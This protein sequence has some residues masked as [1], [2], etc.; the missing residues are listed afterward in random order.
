MDVVP[1]RPSLCDGEGCS[2]C[3][4]V[5]VVS[6]DR[7]KLQL[8][9]TQLLHK[10]QM[11]AREQPPPGS[12]TLLARTPTSTNAHHHQQLIAVH[13][14]GA[15]SR[16]SFNANRQP[17]TPLIAAALG[18]LHSQRYDS[19]RYAKHGVAAP[20][21]N[22]DRPNP[23]AKRAAAAEPPHPLLCPNMLLPN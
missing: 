19:I 6:G 13:L 9:L 2:L 21:R 3:G 7:C 20:E 14:V 4:F 5:G 17:L 18:Q 1:L 11:D 12:N 15:C 16:L 8:G 22:T 23:L 10:Q